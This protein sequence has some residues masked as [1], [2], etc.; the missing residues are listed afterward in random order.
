MPQTPTKQ[1][2]NLQIFIYGGENDDA[3][4]YP[5]L[6]NSMD[7]AGYSPSAGRLQ[8]IGSQRVRQN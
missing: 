6:E 8:S 1:D 3:L 5:C 2:Q 7:L 4:Q